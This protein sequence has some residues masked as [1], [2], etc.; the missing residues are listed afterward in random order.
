MTSDFLEKAHGAGAPA[1]LR[2]RTPAI[3]EVTL[4]NASDTEQGLAIAERHG[5]PFELGNAAAKGKR[6]TLA[7][8]GIPIESCD[9]RYRSAVRKAKRY[10][11]RRRRELTIMHGGELGAGP[12]AMLASSGLALAGSRLLYQLAGETM[13]TGLFAQAARL[14]DS[15]RQQELTA[16]ALA[17]REAHARADDD[18]ADLRARQAEFQRKLAERQKGTT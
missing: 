14:A 5:R 6:P 8:L 17:E 9:P 4:P 15:S 11:D 1:L 7:S 16:V 3:D 12:C 18:Q 10:V 13:D 2:A